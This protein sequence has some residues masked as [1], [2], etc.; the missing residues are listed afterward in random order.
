MAGRRS[1]QRSG[2]SVTSIDVAAHV[3]VSQAT[4]ARVFSSPDKVAPATR[5]RV[6]AAAAELGYVPNAIARS[7]KSQRTNIVAA[8]VPSV[9]EY[10]QHVLT[11]FS[12]QLAAMQRQLL[13]FSFADPSQIETVIGSLA[14]YRVD[15]VILASANIDPGQLSR[16]QAVP[17]PIVAFN[18]PAAAG[19]VPSVSVDNARGMAE[20]ADH[21]VDVGVRTVR[22]V[23]GVSSTSTD[24]QRYRGASEALADAGIACPYDEAGGFAYAD[25]HAI[26]ARLV[27]RGALP[28]AVMVAGDELA[29]GVIDGLEDRGVRVPD[30]VLITGFDGLPQAAWA[31]YDLTTL[32]QPTEALVT[33]AVDLL[34]TNDPGPA[35]A[36]FV[37]P[38]AVRLGRTTKLPALPEPTENHA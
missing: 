31:G 16:A 22:Y 24:Q 3:G 27:D 36:E 2:G 7:L 11:A 17:V 6:E 18:Q 5:E 15:G 9:G 37:A 38:G 28:D 25:G 35:P 34:S 12:R 23:G 20:L 32:T 26:A 30:D 19:V 8:V 33:E 10:W 13:L 1:Q 14:Q 4:V 21:L 29:F